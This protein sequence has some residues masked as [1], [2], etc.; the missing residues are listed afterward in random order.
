[1]YQNYPRQKYGYG[2]RQMTKR[3]YEEMNKSS[4]RD[5]LGIFLAWFFGALLV[6]V[7]VALVNGLNFR[8]LL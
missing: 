4:K 6:Y 5:W 1:M 3:E 2:E 8:G 7:T